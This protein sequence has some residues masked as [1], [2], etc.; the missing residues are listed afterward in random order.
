MQV[1]QSLS[2]QC[3]HL[4]SLEGRCLAGHQIDF[5]MVVNIQIP[6]H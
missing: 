1:S 3:I 2:Y 5:W 6:G 4:L